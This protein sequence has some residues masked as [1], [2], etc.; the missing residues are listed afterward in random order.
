MRKK[1]PLMFP[2][3]VM[4]TMLEDAAK[5]R[6]GVLWKMPSHGAAMALRQRLYIERDNW[7]KKYFTKSGQP[8]FPT[9]EKLMMYVELEKL[10]IIIQD[11]PS[12]KSNL[13]LTRDDIH[14]KDLVSED[15]VTGRPRMT[16]KD[17]LA[18]L[19]LDKPAF[20]KLFQREPSDSDPSITT[21][22]DLLGPDDTT[23]EARAA[24]AARSSDSK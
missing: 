12:G 2:N 22:D 16:L 5:S 8:E 18:P 23:D 24:D 4:E 13:I 11:L 20:P 21:I 1:D 14:L 9:D 15:P 17:L 10:K 19:E 6:N 7:R 3:L